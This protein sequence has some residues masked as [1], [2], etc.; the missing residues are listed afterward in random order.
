MGIILGRHCVE[1]LLM[2]F[3]LNMQV[4]SGEKDWRKNVLGWERSRFD[5]R[6]F[7]ATIR[8]LDQEIMNH[9]SAKF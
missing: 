2:P 3:S 9:S 6:G 4:H 1:G 5:G 8:I 7:L